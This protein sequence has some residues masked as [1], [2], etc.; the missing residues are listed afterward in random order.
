M[1]KKDLYVGILI[2]LLFS[3]FP[4]G[5]VELLSSFR[6]SAEPHLSPGWQDDS[7]RTDYENAAWLDRYFS[8]GWSIAWTT[9]QENGTAG[10]DASAGLG[11]LYATF[12]NSLGGIMV[13]K[14]VPDVD[15]EEY[16]YLVVE[17][18]ETSSDESL[19]FSFGVT[20][21]KGLWHD[22]GW[23]H[24]STSW[25]ELKFDLRGLINGTIAYISIRLTNDF[26]PSY[27]GGEQSAY[28]Q[29]IGI[30]K[31]SPDWTIAYIGTTNASISSE[32]GTLEIHGS[33]GLSTGTIVSAQRLNSL[34]F[35][36]SEYNYLKVSIKTSSINVSA[37]IVIWTDQS[38]AYTVLLKTY[39]DNAWH[40][41]IIDLSFFGATN[42]S[43]YMIEL[44]WMQID[45]GYESTVYYRQLSFDSLG[46]Y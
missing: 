36:P 13:Q 3:V 20:D 38:H 27:A 34:L 8:Q 12:N 14:S 45:K 26:N 11:H 25:A 42:S 43:L 32:N 44:S 5:Y 22:G 18:K 28:V 31:E 7:F 29:L 17:H 40:T 41:E 16:P 46:G 15:T 35:N 10:F 33:G 1:K 24:T 37:R 30:Y 19:M 21:N 39:D 6:S 9:D 2:I 4:I 23:Y